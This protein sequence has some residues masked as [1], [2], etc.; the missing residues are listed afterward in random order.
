[1]GKLTRVKDVEG[2]VTD[3]HHESESKVRHEIRD[4]DGNMLKE[5]FFQDGQLRMKDT[6]GPDTKLRKSET[7]DADGKLTGEKNYDTTGKVVDK[8]SY[9]ADGKIVE[10]L[11]G[12]GHELPL[13][14]GRK[15]ELEKAAAER[16]AADKTAADSS[17]AQL[18][19]SQKAIENHEAEKAAADKA[20]ADKAANDGPYTVKMKDGSELTIDKGGRL[21]RVKEADGKVSEF[22]Y[23][24]NGTLEMQQTFDSSGKP[25][26]DKAF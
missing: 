20:A 22:E 6:Y 26:Y 8:Y 13:T 2:N 12:N 4:K 5:K 10:A 14:A 24:E 11:D 25:L 1:D 16:V 15:A 21:T 23:R 3:I 7:Y 9:D 19:A 17:I 18:A